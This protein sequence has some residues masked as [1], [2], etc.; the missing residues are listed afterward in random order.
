MA[1][2]GRRPFGTSETIKRT[3]SG[4]ADTEKKFGVTCYA[5]CLMS[6]HVHLLVEGS[7]EPLYKFMQG[8]QQAYTQDF[9]RRHNKVGHLFQ[10]RY[11][12]I[13]LLQRTDERI[14]EVIFFSRSIVKQRFD[15]RTHQLVGRAVLLECRLGFGAQYPINRTWIKTGGF[16][17]LLR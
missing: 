12:A 8:L 3:W 11:H 16:Q 14:F 2:R 4:F 5:Y 17:S 6:N 7:K 10:G 9:N 15:A 1:T 13:E